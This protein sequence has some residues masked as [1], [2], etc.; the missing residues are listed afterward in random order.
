MNILIVDD[1]TL[2]R[3][4][5]RTT[6]K[7]IHPELTIIGEASS[8]SEAYKIIT[9]TNPDIVLLDVEMPG[10]NG[11][12]LLQKCETLYSFQTIF[13][14]AHEKYA[15]LAVK[16]RAADYLLKPLE[17]EEL[18]KTIQKLFK[19]YNEE[20]K[21]SLI[22]EELEKKVVITHSK[23]YSLIQLKDIIELQAENNYTIITLRDNKELVCSQTLGKFETSLTL[24]WFFR[25]HRSHI[26]NLY[27]LQEFLFADGGYAKMSNG[28]KL[29]VSSNRLK[30]F[31]NMIHSFCSHIN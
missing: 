5:I 29:N 15:R 4:L 28:K 11:F 16:T 19:R 22:K 9:K 20:K 13:L 3:D 2:S 8:V 31:K 18:E 25:I 26:I 24:S 23:G 7:E 27:H 21:G 1:E 17:K 6:L 30:P 10:G 12:E 14:T